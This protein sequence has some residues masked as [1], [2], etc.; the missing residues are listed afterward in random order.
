MAFTTYQL[1]DT[2]LVNMTRMCYQEQGTDEGAA[3]EASLACNL[4]ELRYKGNYKGQ[5]GGDGLVSYCRNGGWFGHAADV[6][7]GLRGNTKNPSESQKNIIYNVICNGQRTVPG[8]IDEHD[9]FS[10]ISYIEGGG[11][12]SD[13]SNYVQ[14]QTKIHNIYGSTYTF[15]GF[16]GAGSD[17]FGY[18]S[19]ANRQALGDDCSSITGDSGGLAGST[20]V[21]VSYETKPRV[22]E[23]A[24]VMQG[25]G[26]EDWK[27]FYKFNMSSPSFISQM[28]V[29]YAVSA[30]TGQSG[31]RL[32]FDDYSPIPTSNCTVHF[33]PDNYNYHKNRELLEGLDKHYVFET[34][35]SSDSNVID[36]N[37]SCSGILTAITGGG[38]VE[39]TVLDAISNE[40]ISDYH[41]K[42]KDEYAP[43][44]GDSTDVPDT[45]TIITGSS[46]SR[47][48]LEALS[49]SLWY[50]MRSIGYEADLIIVGDPD[51]Q[52]QSICTVLVLKNGVPHYTSGVYLITKIVDDITAGT[53][54]STLSLVRNAMD[55]AADESGGLNI[56]LGQNTLYV[57]SDA[58][59]GGEGSGTSVSAVAGNGNVE[60]AVQWAENIANDPA[61]GYDWGSRDG[62]DYDCSSLVYHAFKEGGG[63]NVMSGNSAG[64]THTMRKDF[65]AA[66]FTWIPGAFTTSEGLTRGDIL[67]DES[68]H[69]EIYV[70]GNKRV[71]A[72]IAENGGCYAGQ[73]GDQTGREIS[74]TDYTSR[75]WDGVLRFNG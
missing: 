47:S 29:P 13:R 14:F 18:T 20:R 37:P 72:H 5:S 52:V 44:T 64:S 54:Q 23:T 12:V 38:A 17:P 43:V 70:G 46:A 25:D 55:M 3:A 8:Y 42:Y 9:C 69:V 24:T 45:V 6:M 7:D 21:A 28:L 4:F 26:A 75:A 65:T 15:W 57:G 63:F 48:E 22:I 36:F 2:Q 59:L 1:T 67:L 11:N 32:W 31:Y 50:N 35:A 58:L 39:A 53:F 71:G 10:D 66:G 40:I 27:T 61:H 49:S 30:E 34:G 68:S 73:K 60:A 74:I 51:L 19:E 16:P 56:T 62:P 41:N 33:K